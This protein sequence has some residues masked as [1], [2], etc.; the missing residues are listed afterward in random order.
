ML[1]QPA[2]QIHLWSALLSQ[3][4]TAP[5]TMVPTQTL[6]TTQAPPPLQMTRP[7]SPSPRGLKET[8]PTTSLCLLRATLSVQVCVDHSE[9]VGTL[10]INPGVHVCLTQR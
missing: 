6:L 10:Y 1:T 3:S 7:P 5:L 2:Q 9:Q 4:T 8:P